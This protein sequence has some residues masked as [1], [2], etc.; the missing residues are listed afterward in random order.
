MSLTVLHT[1][2]LQFAH[3]AHSSWHF[4]DFTL[5]EQDK[6]LVLGASGSGKTTFLHLLCGLLSPNEGNIFF[7]GQAYSRLS[8]QAMDKLRAQQMGLIFQ[9]PFFIKSLSVVENIALAGKLGGQRTSPDDID[10]ILDSLHILHTRDKKTQQL[11]EGEKQRA[12]IARALAC[13]PAILFA[14]EPTS[15]LDDANAADVCSLLLHTAE[16][17][18]CALVLVTHD[19]RIKPHFDLQYLIGPQ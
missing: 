3:D 12:S 10:E 8:K 4:P 7:K 6:I 19:A 5:A 14:D 15:A 9:R 18:K 13:K 17:N 16:K 11:S 2:D 1:R